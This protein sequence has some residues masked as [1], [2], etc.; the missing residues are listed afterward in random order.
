MTIEF[1]TVAEGTIAYQRQIG[2][3]HKPGIIFLCGYASDMARSKAC[4]LAQKCVEEN[5]NFIRF[6]Y[7]G[8]GQSKG[9][10]ADGTIGR[11][12]EDSLTVLDQLTE[13]PQIL[14]GSSM[15]GWMGLLMAQKRA[16]R[17]KAFIGIAAAPDFT[18]ELV[19]KQL[20]DKRRK[21]LLRDGEI[22]DDDAPSDHQVPMTLK[23]IEEARNH[24][25]LRTVMKI[26]CPV[27]LLQGKK[28]TEVP[29]SY[30]QRIADHIANI[31]TRITLIE[32]GDHFLSTEENLRLLWQT[33]AEF[34]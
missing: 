23:L 15:G 26:T 14:V 9:N 5:I 16:T 33:I 6:D 34:L 21:I 13:G 4:F 18:E 29:W 27:R 17:I 30:A 11:W 32:N 1:L 12:C 10:F 8:C 3:A 25:V 22:Y 20:T 24:L 19:W 7:S 31:D 28:D 2:D